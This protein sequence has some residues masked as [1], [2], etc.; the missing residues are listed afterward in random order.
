MAD[1]VVVLLDVEVGEEVVEFGEEELD[2]P[3]LGI[4]FL[5]GQ[6]RALAAADLV[7]ENYGDGVGKG[8]VGEGE[9][10]VVRDA[11]A[12]VEDDEG[13]VVVEEGGGP[14]I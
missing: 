5:E 13:V 4:M 7:I 8:E 6:A 1:N 2:G 9:E 10:V 11:G 12:T 3:E 14:W